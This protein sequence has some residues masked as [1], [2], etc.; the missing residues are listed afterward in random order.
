MV[1]GRPEYTNQPSLLLQLC[2]RSI[3]T[4]VDLPMR[5]ET[6]HTIYLKDYAPSPYRI[7]HVDLNFIIGNEATRVRALLT[8]EP[9]E[10]TAPGTPLVLDGDELAL[11]SIAIDGAPLMLSAYL[12]NGNSLTI[13]EP[14]LRRF[15]LETEVVLRPET[16]TKLMGLYRSGGT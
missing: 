2:H 3:Q 9:R 4:V 7:S 11:S 6:E 5:T 10:G 1:A 13:N 16:N 14:P 8:V 15:I 12:A